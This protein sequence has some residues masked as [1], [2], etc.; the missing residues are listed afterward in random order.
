MS[1]VLGII[2]RGVGGL[3]VYKKIR[4][5]STRPIVYFADNGSTPYG[6]VEKNTL[7]ARLDYII[8]FLRQH[9]ATKIILAC[10]SASVVYPDTN[11]VKGIVEFGELSLL[12]AQ[13]KKPGLIATLGTINS[14]VYST[15]FKQK[16]MDVIEQV[17]QT[18]AIH[19]ENG[20]VDGELIEQEA[21]QVMSTLSS[22]DAILMACTHFPAIKDL[23]QQHVAENCQLI[24]PVDELT[25]WIEQNWPEKN[26]AIHTNS[27]FLVTGSKESFIR[28]AKISFNVDIEPQNVFIVDDEFLTITAQQ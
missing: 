13:A 20:L 24:D 3:G 7:K 17:A 23:L 18:F 16:G 12:K 14:A 4:D 21:K 27:K 25:I 5:V 10:N 1:E 15:R 8:N 6:L 19:I 9:S 2:D 22:C 28:S 26:T 11:D